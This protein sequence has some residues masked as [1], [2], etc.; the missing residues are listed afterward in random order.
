MARIHVELQQRW[1]DMDAY[2]HVNNVAYARYFEEARIKLFFMGDTR[3]DTGLEKLFRDDSP[4]GMK[5]VVASQT[6][7]FLE[8]IV[9]SS[10]PLSIEL[11]LGRLGGASLDIY[12]E[13]FTHGPEK[14]VAARCVTTAVVVDGTTMRP[15][16]LTEEAREAASK[17]TDEPL[18][19]GRR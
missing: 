2:Q 17:W 8:P 11:W 3:E 5:M 18:K 14:R 16:R 19:L 1:S 9:Y 12:G 4:G 13:L 15:K 6:I 10:E 7:D